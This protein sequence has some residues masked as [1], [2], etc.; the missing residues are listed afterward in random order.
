MFSYR[1]PIQDIMFIFDELLAAEMVLNEIEQWRELTSDDVEMIVTEAGKFCEERIHPNNYRM[2]EE[3]CKIVDEKVVTPSGMQEIYQEFAEAGWLGLC[4]NEE[5]GGQA[6]P[7]LLH[8]V[9]MELL[10]SSCLAFSDYIGTFCCTYD[11]VKEYGD[12]HIKALYLKGLAQG[13]IGGSQCMTE[14]QAGTDMSLCRTRAEIQANGS[15][16]VTGTKIFIS[17]GDQ[18]LTENIVHI[19]LARIP[20]DGAGNRGLSL[21]LVPKYLPSEE[22]TTLGTLNKV[23]CTGIEH[24]MGYGAQATC[25]MSFEG[26]TGWLMGERG[27]GLSAM[28][29]M[30]NEARLSVG[31]QGFSAAAAAYQHASAY[32][33]ERLQG[34]SAKT[35]LLPDKPAD[36][37]IVHPDVRRL[38]LTSRAF[39]EAARA[40]YYWL[41]LEY[42]KSQQHPDNT[43]RDESSQILSLLTSVFKAISSD[44]GFQSTN[45][46]MQIFGG[47]GYVRETGIEHYV[48]DCRVTQ[49][50]EGANG[51]LAADLLKRF[52]LNSESDGYRIFLQTVKADI[53]N[54]KS[55]NELEPHADALED[56]LQL[57]MDS[58]DWIKKQA[59]K[60]TD[61]IGAAGIDYQRIFGLVLFGW[62]WVRIMIV[63]QSRITSGDESKAGFYADKIRTG[64]FFMT[65]I[66]PS[67]QSH[68]LIIQASC[69]SLMEPP[70][71]Y[72]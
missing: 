3:G 18:D 4:A 39:T 36:P 51:M 65:R 62:M 59:E 68:W 55:V 29:T 35:R 11:M 63:A 5:D 34:R 41:G 54:A 8:F 43:V 42:D 14:P 17:G 64:S 60:D 44:F 16:A 25:Q 6:L 40:T 61:E 23:S 2:G 15:Y 72:F 53:A 26:A 32:A 27:R 70:V 52:V 20:E 31:C 50:Y 12:E 10:G 67:C 13:K 69:N 58:T 33:K 28:F 9:L 66:L 57:L 46:A 49:I 38:L 22:E 48:R 21:F 56:A 37:L 71:A 24:K 47:H 30:V 1:T 7:R 45:D 19:V